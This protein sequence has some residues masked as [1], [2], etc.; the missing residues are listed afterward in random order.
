[1]ENKFNYNIGKKFYTTEIINYR[2]FAQGFIHIL[3]EIE[4]RSNTNYD[5]A[6][7]KVSLYNNGQKLI[8]TTDISILNFMAGQVRTYDSNTVIDENEVADIDNIKIQ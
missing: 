1:M 6:I 7:F 3:G 8:G 2:Y 5:W 4:N